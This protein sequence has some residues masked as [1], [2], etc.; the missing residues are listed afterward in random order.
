MQKDMHFFDIF[1]EQMNEYYPVVVDRGSPYY[2]ESERLEYPEY[3][4]SAEITDYFMNICDEFDWNNVK[5]KKL[6]SGTSEITVTWRVM[7]LTKDE[8]F[9]KGTTTGYGQISEG[10]PNGETL[11]VERAFEDALNKLPEIDCFNSTVAQRIHPDDLQSQIN[12]LK[13]MERRNASIRNQYAR[14]LK[15][16]DVLQNCVSGIPT[17]IEDIKDEFFETGDSC[18]SANLVKGTYVNGVFVEDEDGMVGGHYVDG[19]FIEDCTE[20]CPPLVRGRYENGKFVEDDKG[21]VF[22][23]FVDGKFAEEKILS[24]NV[25]RGYYTLDGRFVES[26]DGT[27]YGYYADN[28]KFIEELDND[29]CDYLFGRPGI[30]ERSGFSESYSQIDGTSGVTGSGFDNITPLPTT[31]MTEEECAR[32]QAKETDYMIELLLQNLEEKNLIENTVIVVFTDH[33]LYTLEDK[34]ILDKYKN[35]ANNLINHT[36]F[37]IWSNNGEKININDVTSQLNILPTVL[38]LFG[39]N[40]NPN[41]YIGSD[42]LNPQYEGIVFFSDYSWYDGNVYVENGEVANNK[43]ISYNQLEEKNYYINYITKKN[44]LAL[45]FNYFK[46]K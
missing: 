24:G 30:D 17:N 19:K 28:G 45:K 8:V 6:R 35:T 40:Y 25:V 12:E 42:A 33:Y 18:D 41:N 43:N 34:T 32:R 4:V 1:Y 20:P 3:L 15:G 39:I 36:P 9:C 2:M 27:I 7:D 29:E 21:T 22:G 38:N 5:Q 16:I 13:E 14:E 26:K 44:D 31:V 11:L 46:D 23:R 37:F 10:E